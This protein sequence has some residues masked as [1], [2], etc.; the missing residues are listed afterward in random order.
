MNGRVSMRIAVVLALGLAVVA[1]VAGPGMCADK[2]VTLKGTI[3][4]AK[5]ELQE[6][7]KCQTVIRVKEEGKEVTYYF[8]DKGSKEEYHENVCGGGRQEGSVVGTVTEKDGKKWI[9]PTKV[10]YAKK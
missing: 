7:G 10:Q 3:M 4:C 6:P 8:K 2:V 9:T 1:L 5:C